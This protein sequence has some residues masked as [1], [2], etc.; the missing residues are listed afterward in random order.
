MVRTWVMTATMMVIITV[1]PEENFTSVFAFELL[2]TLFWYLDIFWC[3]YVLLNKLGLLVMIHSLL[4]N[5]MEK[6]ELM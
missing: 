1:H 4:W 5:V 3:N 2:M 6:Y